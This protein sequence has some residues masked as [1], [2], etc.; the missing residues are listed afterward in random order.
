MER[1]RLVSAGL[2]P[3]G[4]GLSMGMSGDFEAAINEGST[5]VR[6][7]SALFAGVERT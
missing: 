4:A 3:P 2:L 6:I 1:G 7:G 5:I